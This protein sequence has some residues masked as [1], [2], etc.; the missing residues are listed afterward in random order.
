[1]VTTNTN[2][3][4]LDPLPALDLNG[5]SPTEMQTVDT[6]HQ[7]LLAQPTHGTDQDRVPV[8]DSL[9]ENQFP[10][11]SSPISPEVQISVLSSP[12][13]HGEMFD[14]NSDLGPNPNSPALCLPTI[15]G[16]Q[17]SS[18]EQ[19]LNMDTLNNSSESMPEIMNIDFASSEN[20]TFHFL[21]S[22]DQPS[23]V[24]SLSYPSVSRTPTHTT[25]SAIV[26]GPST[27]SDT[28]SVPGS[29]TGHTSA[30]LSV[31]M[32]QSS[33]SGTGFTVPYKK[34]RGHCGYQEC[35]GC[36]RDPCEK[37]YNCLLK[38]EKR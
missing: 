1:M 19:P 31:L 17:L 3:D 4:Q 2:H 9:C 35:E 27:V 24:D 32:P 12:N 14:N 6:R 22:N 13:H 8:S 16:D 5:A 25:A 11:Q 37:C 21:F 36:N 33:A 18:A 34:V 15:P 38:K 7:E 20:E 28:V 23:L 10:S 30:Q 29:S 26:T